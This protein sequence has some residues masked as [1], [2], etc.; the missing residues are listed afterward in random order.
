[1]Y[2]GERKFTKDNNILGKFDLNG[3]PPMPRGQPQIEVTFNVDAN[4]ILQVE[5]SEKSSGKKE[6]ITIKAEKG[7]LSEEEIERMVNEAEQFKEQ[8]EQYAAKVEA[9]NAF[10]TY[11]FS[12]RNSIDE[13]GFKANVGEDEH[14]TLKAAVDAALKWLDDNQ[15]AEKD[16]YDAQ[17]KELEELAFPILQKAN[18]AGTG[19][20]AAGAAGGAAGGASEADA[21][22]PTVEEV[23]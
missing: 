5:A 23:D 9:R 22:G 6:T 15:A 14:A 2:E 19:V 20:G 16:E 18:A 1:V 3:I 7:R 4:G 8:D 11:V 10:E 13:A 12:L 17:R 21:D